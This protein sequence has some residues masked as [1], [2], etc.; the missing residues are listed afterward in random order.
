MQGSMDAAGGLPWTSPGSP[1]HKMDYTTYG[2]ELMSTGLILSDGASGVRTSPVPQG[3]YL[4]RLFLV[5]A[6]P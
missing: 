1:E 4:S 6:Q 2:D 5:E 3:D